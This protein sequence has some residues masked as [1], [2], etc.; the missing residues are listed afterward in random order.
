MVMTLMEQEALL[1][2][3]GN[4]WAS[5]KA[6]FAASRDLQI[7]AVHEDASILDDIVCHLSTPPGTCS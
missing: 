5:L 7:E 1:N 3:K 4:P 2:S 6:S